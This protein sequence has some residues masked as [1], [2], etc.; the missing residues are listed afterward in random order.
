MYLMAGSASEVLRHTYRADLSVRLLTCTCL[1]DGELSLL[2][3]TLTGAGTREAEQRPCG[4]FLVGISRYHWPVTGEKYLAA[5]PCLF[6]RQQRVTCKIIRDGL[7]FFFFFF[8]I[9]FLL[10]FS[11]A[12]NT[13]YIQAGSG[14]Q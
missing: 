5:I 6:L 4:L 10:F 11:L 2:K 14:D 13:T 1:D 7:S 9:L 8:S 12:V 3:Y